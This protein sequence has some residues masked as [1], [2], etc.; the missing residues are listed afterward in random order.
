MRPRLVLCCLLASVVL[1][2]CGNLFDTAAA[3]VGGRKIT[4]QEVSESTDLFKESGDYQQLAQQGNIEAI[5]RQVEQSALS[6]LIR[7]AV[8]DIE[9]AE[10]GIQV[11]D[12]EVAE[13]LEAIKEDAGANYAEQLKEGGLTEERLEAR[14]QYGLLQDKI[15]EEV[16]AGTAP[17]E[18]EVEAFYEENIIDY[19]SMRA[20]HILVDDFD[21]AKRIAEQL[22]SAPE[23]EVDRLFAQLAREFSID[24]FSARKGGDLGFTN[25]GDLNE[26]FEAAAFRLDIG[27]VSDPVQT[28]DGYHIIRVVE[29]ETR[30]LE[31][32]GLAISEQ[33]GEG[34]E[35]Q[36]WQEWL[37]EAYEEAD[38]KINSRYGEL[39]PETLIVVDATSED[40][41]GVVETP[42]PSPTG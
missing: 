31:D 39:D 12:E 3:V 38:I 16:T 29:R 33:L 21:S 24:R 30:P 34:E 23:K 1:T 14:I 13:Q 32:V 11:S 27:E 35:E 7:R 19:T 10:L 40:I 42:S 22:Q 4:V 18:A 26:R 20:H 5:L 6:E 15:R 8:L 17:S 36:E 2:A 9:A 41:P 28:E 37:R 25:A